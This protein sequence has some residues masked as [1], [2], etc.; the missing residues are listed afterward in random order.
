[1]F[2]LGVSVAGSAVQ[3]T[4]IRP[5]IAVTSDLQ[6]QIDNKESEIQRLQR[7]LAARDKQVE[8]L[9]CR[10]ELMQIGISQMQKPRTK[11]ANAISSK[12][13]EQHCRQTVEAL[14]FN[15]AARRGGH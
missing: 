6:K 4:S 2:V 15:T 3:V 14:R 1:M 8:E 5:S 7:E 11:R 10:V 12:P 9:R 13:P